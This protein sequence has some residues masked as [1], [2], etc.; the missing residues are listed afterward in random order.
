M[1]YTTCSLPV[2]VGHLPVAGQG[3][4][5]APEL[6]GG[7]VALS[8]EQ[9]QQT[10]GLAHTSATGR[11]GRR[12]HLHLP[13]LEALLSTVDWPELRLQPTYVV[14]TLAGHLSHCTGSLMDDCVHTDY[15]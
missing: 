13:Q 11:T 2:V 7:D 14:D 10:V 1:P 4:H 3:L 6:V 9:G 8:E 5:A 15:W 12:D